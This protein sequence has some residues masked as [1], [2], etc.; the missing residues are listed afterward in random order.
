MSFLSEDLIF[1]WVIRCI[2]IFKYF[3]MFIV[4]FIH[5]KKH[6][7][8]Y[9]EIVHLTCNEFGV[10]WRLTLELYFKT[11]FLMM[12]YFFEVHLWGKSVHIMIT[13]VLF[14]LLSSH[15]MLRHSTVESSVCR[16]VG[17]SSPLRNVAVLNGG[18]LISVYARSLGTAAFISM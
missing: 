17:R 4:A 11:Y 6:T 9:T 2:Q 1:S 16:A 7:S 8:E 5:L 12:C 13:L 18:G 14:G 3:T 15:S 10:H